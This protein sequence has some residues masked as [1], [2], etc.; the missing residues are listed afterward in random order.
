MGS[1]LCARYALDSAGAQLPFC[2]SA[3]NSVSARSSANFCAVVTLARRRQRKPPS[4]DCCHS[5]TLPVLA[6][7]VIVPDSDGP[8]GPLVLPPTLGALSTT[9]YSLYVSLAGETSP[10]ILTLASS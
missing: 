7:S 10:A 6:V 2:T 9:V 8:A 4:D 5:R 1:L 3:R